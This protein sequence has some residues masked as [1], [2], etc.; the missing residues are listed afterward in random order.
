MYTLEGGVQAY[1]EEF[2]QT[3]EQRW[4][5]QLFV[6]DSRLAMT[7]D[8]RPSSEAGAAAAVLPCYCCGAAR[9]AAPHRNCPNVDCNRLFL[10]CAA[11]LA[12]RGGFCCPD[13]SR[14]SHVRQGLTLVPRSLSAQP[15]LLVV[16]PCTRV[17][18]KL[19]ASSSLALSAQIPVG[20]N[21]SRCRSGGG[22]EPISAKILRRVP[23]HCGTRATPTRSHFS[24]NSNHHVSGATQLSQWPQRNTSKLLKLR[25]RENEWPDP[26]EWPALLQPGQYQKY[27]HY[28]DSTQEEKKAAERRG[29]G[30][31][32]RRQRRR[33][34]RR[35][36]HAAESAAAVASGASPRDL[37]RAV[38]VLEKAA[39]DPAAYASGASGTIAARTRSIVK[40]AGLDPESVGGSSDSGDE[41][42]DEAGPC[43]VNLVVPDTA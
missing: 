14:A 24:S 15:A 23:V 11:C 39:A 35:A 32:L 41:S 4:E 25:C 20:W 21:L 28:N 30:R 38:R 31:R 43:C 3:E 40:A 18:Y 26:A 7:P 6:F 17:S 16:Y 9:A 8:G 29:E 22:F 42:G 33:D 13:C 37:M 27:V 2:G 12:K 36:E 19:A 5:N 34:G 10:V 1:F